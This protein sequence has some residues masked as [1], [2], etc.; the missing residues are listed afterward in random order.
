MVEVDLRAAAYELVRAGVAAKVRRSGVY[1]V[2]MPNGLAA[3]LEAA[4]VSGEDV[5]DVIIRLAKEAKAPGETLSLAL[6]GSAVALL[7]VP[8][9]SSSLIFGDI[10]DDVVD[11][12]LDP[13]AGE[14]HCRPRLEAARV[15]KKLR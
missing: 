4:R 12:L 14:G 9:S 11:V 7:V 15:R 8:A 2:L 1:T 5:S 10:G 6:D 3:N 13:K